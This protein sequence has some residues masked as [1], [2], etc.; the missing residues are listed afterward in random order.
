MKLGKAIKILDNLE[1]PFR[2]FSV[3]ERKAAAKLGI[4]ALKWR[5]AVEHQYRCFDLPLLPGETEE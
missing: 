4:E 5:K 3:T 2:L 1:D